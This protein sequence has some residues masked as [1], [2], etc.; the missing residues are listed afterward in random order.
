M[1]YS[2]NTSQHKTD[3]DN[4]HKQI[5]TIESEKDSQINN[6]NLQFQYESKLFNEQLQ[7]KN[8]QIEYEAKLHTEQLNNLNS[9][10]RQKDLEFENF[11]LKSQLDKL[12]N[13]NNI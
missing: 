1:L 2:G 12:T 3:V 6:L 8:L 4:L 10:L 11:K 13:H 5:L 7:Q 9:I